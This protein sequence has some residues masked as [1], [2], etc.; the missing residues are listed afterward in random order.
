M[1]D[2]AGKCVSVVATEPHVDNPDIIEGAE[3]AIYYGMAAEDNAQLMVL[4]KD[5]FQ[6]LVERR[7]LRKER[8]KRK[9]SPSP[10]PP[11]PIKSMAGY[12]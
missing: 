5:A 7:R 10:S 3:L 2:M 11:R 1:I 8:E 4:W 12:I 9:R 6:D